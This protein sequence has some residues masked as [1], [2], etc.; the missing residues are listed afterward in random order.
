[1]MANGILNRPANTVERARSIRRDAE[2]CSLRRDLQSALASLVTHEGECVRESSFGA[3][4]GL[5]NLI[6]GGSLEAWRLGSRDAKSKEL[7]QELDRAWDELQGA[8]L[9]A[10]PDSVVTRH[11]GGAYFSWEQAIDL[12][13]LLLCVHLLGDDIRDYFLA[14][15]LG[16]A[17][18]VVNTVGKQFAQPIRPRD[19]RGHVKTHLVAQIVRDRGMSALDAFEA[20]VARF[21]GGGREG[22]RH[23]AIRA[24]YR[25]VLKDRRIGFDAIYADPPYTRDHY[26]RYYHVLETMARHDDPTVSTTAIRSRGERR[27]SRGLYR[28]DRH[29]SPFCIK[30]Q[31]AEAFED[32]F[33]GGAVRGVPLVVSYSPYKSGNRPR[34]M[35][36]EEILSIAAKYYKNVEWNAV[37]G[38]AHNKFN[39][40]ER[41][42]AV[43]DVAE[44]IVTCRP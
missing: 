38:V 14:A 41:N 26:S 13:A 6:L 3:H 1:M 43:R 35:T 10:G 39:H 19:N 20:W 44:V 8:R 12:D 30:S 25:E 7:S 42:V 15:V 34:L 5:C 4:R 37:S 11:F 36:V 29:Q 23:R 9:D 32:L 28:E 24:D 2:R 22:G 17:S 16:A 40:A 33:R 21:E 18:E 27:P 31:A